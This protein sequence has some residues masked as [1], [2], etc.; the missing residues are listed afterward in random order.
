MVLHQHPQK[1]K[2]ALAVQLGMEMNDFKASMYQ[3]R[4]ALVP[5]PLCSCWRDDQTAKHIIMLFRTSSP[6][7]HSLRDDQGHL[8]DYMQLLATLTALQK[9]TK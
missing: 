8:L 2:T 6:A 3:A 5:S 9:V 7:S 1:P 4:V